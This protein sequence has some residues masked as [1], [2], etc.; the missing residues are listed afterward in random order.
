MWL[1]SLI[2]K[3]F[4]IFKCFS[5]ATSKLALRAIKRKLCCLITQI[6]LL[7]YQNVCCE[8]PFSVKFLEVKQDLLKCS[9]AQSNLSPPFTTFY[10]NFRI[11]ET[12]NRNT[13]GRKIYFERLVLGATE[14][15]LSLLTTGRLTPDLLKIKRSLGVPIVSLEDAIIELSKCLIVFWQI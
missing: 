7:G 6:P 3:S 14:A 2:S 5:N 10:F 12:Q 15:K 4:Y 1:K 13:T 9:Y 8:T 11:L